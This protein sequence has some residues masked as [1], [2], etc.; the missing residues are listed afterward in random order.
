[1]KILAAMSGG[2][3]SS[4]AAGLLIEAGHEV[5]GA[6]L[7]L[8]LAEDTGAEDACRTLGVAHF[9]VDGAAAFRRHVLDPFLHGYESGETPNPCV[10]CNPSVKFG[11]LLE[12]ALS[13]GYDAVATG[14]YARVR[15]D[16]LT[17][18]ASL[19]RAADRTKDQ[20]YVLCRLP[21]EILRRVIFPLGGLT[22]EEVRAWA[23]RKGLAAAD[24][25]DSQDLCFVYNNEYAAFIEE[26][27]GKHYPE[28][29]I[30]DMNGRVIGRH[31]GLVRYTIGQRRGLGV[32]V[33]HPIYVT[34]KD[35]SLNT[36]TLGPESALYSKTVY[37][38]NINLI[39]C[40]NL[41][42]PMRIKAK[43]RYLQEENPAVVV[44]TD[45]DQIRID[46]D[47]G[48]RAVTPGQSVVLYDGDIV[49]GG[50]VIQRTVNS[51]Q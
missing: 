12:F 27:T 30:L 15:T 48:Q 22:K 21:Q 36:V 45:P 46:F 35:M 38:D 13:R 40:D 31:R 33:N 42:N 44:Q 23:A 2:V 26:F 3:D 10:V 1:M 25:A 34:G 37:A 29:D 43:T 32:A 51:E 18:C 4:V 41:E 49:V 19:L 20:S 14:H 6:T 28:G 7:L 39:A 8:G 50:G 5:V 24:R 9:A 16:E 11:L 47:E 17:G